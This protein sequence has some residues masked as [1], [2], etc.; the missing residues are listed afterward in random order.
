MG[1]ALP[2]PTH[3]GAEAMT[4]NNADVFADWIFDE[5]NC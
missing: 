3:V 4:R 2:R 5:R 1:Q